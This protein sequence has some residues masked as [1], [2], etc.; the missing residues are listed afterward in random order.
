MHLLQWHVSIWFRNT[1]TKFK[2]SQ[3]QTWVQQSI[4]GPGKQK[5]L[6][7]TD[8]YM[9]NFMNELRKKKK[10]KNIKKNFGNKIYL[11]NT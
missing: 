5:Y 6:Q 2:H 10:I 7:F 3:L 4:K 11:Y 8:I 1:A 9:L